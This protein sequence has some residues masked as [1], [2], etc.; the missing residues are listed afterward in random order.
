MVHAPALLQPF[1]QYPQVLPNDPVSTMK[2]KPL[3]GIFTTRTL[4]TVVPDMNNC[5]CQQSPPLRQK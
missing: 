1:W 2:S 4:Y 5:K 3:H